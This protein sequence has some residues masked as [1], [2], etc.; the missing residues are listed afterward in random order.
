MTLCR[1]MS[2]KSTNQLHHLE[3]I[4]LLFL[5]HFLAL[6]KD[7]KCLICQ[8]PLPIKTAVCNT[9]NQTLF[10]FPLRCYRHEIIQTFSIQLEFIALIQSA[11][12]PL[13]NIPNTIHN[14]IEGVPQ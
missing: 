7:F 11:L 12:V 9:E 10:P 14:Y 1:R 2:N 5:N 13:G 6:K 8:R 3:R 4:L